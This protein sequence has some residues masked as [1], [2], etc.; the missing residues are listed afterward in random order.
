MRNHSRRAT[1]LT[2]R[3]N[4]FLPTAVPMTGALDTDDGAVLAEATHMT[5]LPRDSDVI[6]AALLLGI[7]LL[8]GIRALL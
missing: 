4:F 8:S 6:G 1:D 2:T 5:T 3:E 7:L